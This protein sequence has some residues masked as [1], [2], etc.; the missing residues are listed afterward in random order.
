MIKDYSGQNLRGCSF[1]GQ[2]L[3]GANFSYADIRSSD[4][5]GA[6]LTGASFSH[7]QT[8]LQKRWAVFLVCICWLLSGFSGVFS[9]F[10]GVLI[11]LICDSSTVTYQHQFAQVLSW[12]V[13]IVVIFVF[14]VILQQG[15]NFAIAIAEVFAILGVIAIVGGFALLATRATAIAGTGAVTVLIVVI[16]VFIVIVS[17][18]FN[19]AIATAIT[20]AG[21]IILI[22]TFGV[23]IAIPQSGIDTTLPIAGAIA[24]GGAFTFVGT[25]AGVIGIAIAL[26]IGVAANIA[27]I[28]S[29]AVVRAIDISA[30][31]VGVLLSGFI[32]WKGIK[33]EEKYSLIHNSA[34]AF[35]SFAGTSFR[36]ANLTDVNFTAAILKST[37]FRKAIVSRTCFH[38]TKKLDLV[39]PGKTYLQNTQV[40]HVLITGQGQQKK[41]DSKDLRGVNF[42]GANLVN[43]S[44]IGTNLSQANLQYADLSR[45][46]LVQAQLDGTDFTGATLTGAY[47]QDWGITSN[48]K[49]DGVKCEYIYMRL[50]TKEN[51]DPLRKPE[52]NQEVFADG[53][54]RTFI[55]SS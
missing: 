53:E 38:K 3:E 30:A 43:A 11:S 32:A 45:V 20:I 35:S 16:F 29:I 13:L 41:F 47:I 14:I 48:T 52:N 46:K 44:F 27:S 5:T 18:K 26:C 24:I 9:A 36:N 23:A 22:F 19:S 42:Q 21:V 49:F 55:K 40:R 28:T 39:R 25:L 51:P 2:N 54:F 33:G 6:N 50:P 4:F 17:Q 10:T 37:D 8:G 7:A 1:K 34:V 12:T 31:I 15:L